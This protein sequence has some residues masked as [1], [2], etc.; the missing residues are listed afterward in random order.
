MKIP[1]LDV[2]QLAKST[3]IILEF[4]LLH[5][6]LSIKLHSNSMLGN[7]WKVMFGHNTSHFVGWNRDVCKHP[8]PLTQGTCHHLYEFNTNAIREISN[9]HLVVLC[10]K[11]WT[12]IDDVNMSNLS[13]GTLISGK[14]ATSKVCLASHLFVYNVENLSIVACWIGLLLWIFGQ[15]SNSTGQL[16]IVVLS[17]TI[18]GQRAHFHV[19]HITNHVSS[20]AVTSKWVKLVPTCIDHIDGTSGLST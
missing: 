16:W 9:H 15:A 19:S 2:V 3:L 20:K 14:T 7:E 11:R 5:D 10:A 6:S 1:L 13:G 4:S 18:R 8:L 12:R 17:F